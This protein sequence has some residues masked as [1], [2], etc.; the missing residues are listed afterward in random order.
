MGSITDIPSAMKRSCGRSDR[1]LT[2]DLLHCLVAD[3]M[4][5]SQPKILEAF[6]Q[7]WDT[8]DLIASFD[9]INITLPINEETGRTDIKPTGAWPRKRSSKHPRYHARRRN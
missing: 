6:A 2:C 3:H 1:K 9:G 7:L 4:N 8:D 5:K